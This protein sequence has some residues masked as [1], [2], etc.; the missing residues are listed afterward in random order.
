MLIGCL[1]TY[2]Q[3]GVWALILLVTVRVVRG[4]ALGAEW[5]GAT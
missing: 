1:P 3:V 4:L 2:G 5:G